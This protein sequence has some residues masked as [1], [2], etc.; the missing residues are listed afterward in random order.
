VTYDHV[1]PE[2]S[3]A[4]E[5]RAE[6]IALLCASCHLRKTKGLL[7]TETISEGMRHPVALERGFA[8]GLF[9]SGPVVPT[10]HIGPV[11][12]HGGASV[13]KI[14]SIPV[15]GFEAPEE[16]GAPLRLIGR[17]VDRS[18]VERFTILGNEF[19]V[20]PFSWDVESVGRTIQIRGEQ[21]A[22]PL[23]IE[24]APRDFLRLSDVHM[25][26]GA[27]A[28]IAN[29]KGIQLK[30][31]GKNILCL[32]PADIS[33]PVMFDVKGSQISSKNMRIEGKGAG[34]RFDMSEDAEL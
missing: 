1:D 24:H 17:F 2:F 30:M 16:K 7:S 6:C 31:N 29:E 11:T 32:G 9:D 22:R 20:N 19:F 18:G 13:L 33:G 10:I 34:S 12:F 21:G 8:N 4:R 15:L 3:E 27:Y 28:F 23:T 25:N 5:H 14:N 26:F